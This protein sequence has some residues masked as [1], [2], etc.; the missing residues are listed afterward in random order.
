MFLLSMVETELRLHRERILTHSFFFHQCFHLQGLC[1]KMHHIANI[2][3]F[4][5][6]E[7]SSLERICCPLWHYHEAASSDQDG[8]LSR[9]ECVFNEKILPDC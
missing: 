9:I 3:V 5:V 6:S 8:V 4:G 2:T 1:K 7:F